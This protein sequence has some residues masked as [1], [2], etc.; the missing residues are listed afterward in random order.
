[1]KSKTAP[2]FGSTPFQEFGSPML[3]ASRAPGGRRYERRRL[4]NPGPASG[5]GPGLSGGR[6]A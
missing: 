6:T 3:D 4:P 2:Y 1:M 5:S